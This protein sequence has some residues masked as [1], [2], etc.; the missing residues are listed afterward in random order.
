[1]RTLTLA[2]AVGIA[3]SPA[4]AQEWNAEQ[5]GLIDHVT[6]CW[7]AWVDALAD[8]TPDRF[9]DACPTPILR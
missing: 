3:A 9:I 4:V 7:D 1:M 6:M 8:E 5:Q 2:L